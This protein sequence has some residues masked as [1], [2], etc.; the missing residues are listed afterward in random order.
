MERLPEFLTG[1]RYQAADGKFPGW[2]AKYEVTTADLFSQE[3]YTSLRTHRSPREADVMGR[4]GTLDRRIF[5]TV[6]DTDKPRGPE[7]ASPFILTVSGVGVSEKQLDD[8]KEVPGW[9]RSHAYRLIDSSVVGVGHAPKLNIAP[10]FTLIHG[11]FLS[12]FGGATKND[13]PDM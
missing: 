8:A 7:A 5:A 11:N 4:I 6:A 1:S 12:L 3:K 2:S 10:P 9:T 13:E